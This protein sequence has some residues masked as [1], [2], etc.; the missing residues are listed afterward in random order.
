[1]LF[2]D[3]NKVINGLNWEKILEIIFMWSLSRHK[4]S[5][6]LMETYKVLN[7]RFIG[8]CLHLVGIF[9][10]YRTLDLYTDIQTLPFGLLCSH[11]FWDF[12]KKDPWPKWTIS[13]N[14]IRNVCLSV[15]SEFCLWSV[16]RLQP[17]P[18]YAEAWNIY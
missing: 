6:S 15:I 4:I 5:E 1:M 11:Y 14:S 18:A 16:A 3:K 7:T 17:T 13:D 10:F 8:Q 9:Q 12:R 2:A